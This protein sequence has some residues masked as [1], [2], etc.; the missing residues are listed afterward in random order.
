MSG[1]GVTDEEWAYK[2][3]V[4]KSHHS[5][6][7]KAERDRLEDVSKNIKAIKNKTTGQPC[8][9]PI[10]GKNM[11]KFKR[12]AIAMQVVKEDIGVPLVFV[13]DGDIATQQIPDKKNGELK[14]SKGIQVRLFSQ[15]IDD[16]EARPR[17]LVLRAQ[18]A[19]LFEA[20]SANKSL[21]GRV[22]E[23]IKQPKPEG[24]DYFVYNLDELF[25]D[26]EGEELELPDPVVVADDGEMEGPF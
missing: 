23:L 13:C 6:Q 2:M 12:E 11:A 20:L 24:K 26:D 22:F 1:I 21:K 4:Y 25:L 16:F 19:K 8:P 14:D 3:R 15:I 9:Q 7:L 10:K 17:M 18:P 5:L